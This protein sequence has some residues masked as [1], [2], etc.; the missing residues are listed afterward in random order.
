[1]SIR[2]SQVGKDSHWLQWSLGSQNTFLSRTATARSGLSEREIGEGYGERKMAVG[3]LEGKEAHFW[4]SSNSC[5]TRVLITCKKNKRD[6][7]SKTRGPAW[8]PSRVLHTP[9][10]MIH[11]LVFT[12][13]LSFGTR[14]FR[15]SCKALPVLSLFLTILLFSSGYFIS[16]DPNSRKFGSYFSSVYLISFHWHARNYLSALRMQMTKERIIIIL[17]DLALPLIRH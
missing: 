3:R 14:Q 4:D 13:F 7:R 12:L 16:N 1:M 9:V 11:C 6:G 2:A 10:M 17:S 5:L 8:I 15:N